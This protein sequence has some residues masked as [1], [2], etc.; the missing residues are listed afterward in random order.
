M[1]PPRPLRPAL[2]GFPIALLLAAVAAIPTGLHAQSPT[3][4]TLAKQVYTCDQASFRAALAQAHAIAVE[5]RPRD[6]VATSQLRDL[7]IALGKTVASPAD[8]TFSLVPLDNTG[9][10]IGPTGTELASLRIYAPGASAKQ[11]DL[12]W[13]ETFSGQPDMTWPTVVHAVIQQFRTRL[14]P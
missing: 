5:A 2:R 1:K 12:L 6:R 4:C 3:P 10:N 8:L 7:V 14:A 13:A 9:V 11:G